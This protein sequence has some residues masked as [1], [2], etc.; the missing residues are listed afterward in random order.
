MLYR[1]QY[2]VFGAYDSEGSIF[3]HSLLGGKRPENRKASLE[4]TQMVQ[5]SE[6]TCFCMYRNALRFPYLRYSDM[7]GDY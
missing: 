4:R 5:K 7:G 6:Q 3:K 2:C 1:I